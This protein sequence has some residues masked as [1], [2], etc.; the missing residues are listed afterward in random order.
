MAQIFQSSFMKKKFKDLYRVLIPNLNK[1]GNCESTKCFQCKVSDYSCVECRHLRCKN[2]VKF[3]H[4]IKFFYEN[5]KDEEW[6]YIFNFL[7]NLFRVDDITRTSFTNIRESIQFP[8]IRTD[9]TV[10]RDVGCSFFKFIKDR[11]IYYY[12]LK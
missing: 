7:H 10:S 2:C 9:F 5:A 3:M 11:C 4:S 8:T 1:C 12:F 6:D